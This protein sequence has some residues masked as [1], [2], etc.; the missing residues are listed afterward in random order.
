MALLKP[1]YQV[2]TGPFHYCEG[3][4]LARG[5]PGSTKLIAVWIAASPDEL[6]AM[7]WMKN[8]LIKS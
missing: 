1:L 3:R 5:N 8:I 4:F 2:R 7:T 6:F